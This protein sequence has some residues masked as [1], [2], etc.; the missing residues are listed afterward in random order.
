MMCLVAEQQNQGGDAPCTLFP[1]SLPP[2]LSSLM[3]VGRPEHKQVRLCIPF[4]SHLCADMF[5]SVTLALGVAVVGFQ[6]W[7]RKSR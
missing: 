4:L 2:S 1:S 3:P 5:M 7:P 6:P